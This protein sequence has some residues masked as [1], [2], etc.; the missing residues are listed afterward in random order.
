MP[1]VT[2]SSIPREPVHSRRRRGSLVNG[3]TPQVGDPGVG[4]RKQ[5]GGV[6][7]G[8]A[9]RQRTVVAQHQARRGLLGHGDHRPIGDGG[10][11]PFHRPPPPHHREE[12]LVPSRGG[13]AW[14]AVPDPQHSKAG[15]MG[16]VDLNL[17]VSLDARPGDAVRPRA[18][19]GG[20]WRRWRAWRWWRSPA[21]TTR[22]R[23][24]SRWRSPGIVTGP[25]DPPGRVEPA[26]RQRRRDRAAAHAAHNRAGHAG[27][28]AGPRFA[29]GSSPFRCGDPFPRARLVRRGYARLPARFR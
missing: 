13:S 6:L 16:G 23:C 12:A 19:P 20:A 28:R 14:V 4:T 26:G 27:Q 7:D 17:L 2:K 29:A 18:D 11:L 15:T 1:A 8:G 25:G 9:G 10:T 3:A 24:R 22:R 21:T 5:N